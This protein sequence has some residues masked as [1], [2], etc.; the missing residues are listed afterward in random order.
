MALHKKHSPL[1]ML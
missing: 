1:T